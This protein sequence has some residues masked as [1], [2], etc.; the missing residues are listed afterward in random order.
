MH[1]MNDLINDHECKCFFLKKVTQL[2]LPKLYIAKTEGFSIHISHIF[3]ISL[4]HNRTKDS[5]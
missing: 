3:K 4:E 2:F 5:M 1:R